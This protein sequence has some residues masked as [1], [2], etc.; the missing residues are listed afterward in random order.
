MGVKVEID[1]FLAEGAAVKVEIDAASTGDCIREVV[2]CYPAMETK[3]FTKPGQLR[4]YM[5]VLVN[6]KMV[7]PEPLSASVRGGDVVSLLVLLAGG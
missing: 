1:P 5:S 6:G 3:I 2:R 7:Y 4:D